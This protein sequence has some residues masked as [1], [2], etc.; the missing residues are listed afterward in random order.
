MLQNEFIAVILAGGQGTRL[1]LLT[2][3]LA[4][5]AVPFGGRYRIIDF[6][7]SNCY[8]SRVDTVG[9][10][11]QYQPFEL[12][13]HVGAGGQEARS[14]GGGI[15]ILPPYMK[16]T[17]GE[18]YK[19]TAN[20]VYQ[21][22]DFIQRYNPQ[23]VLVLSGDHI[24]KM[25]YRT[26]IEQHKQKQAEVTIAAL[27]VPW[28]EASRFG[29]MDI[30]ENLRISQFDEKPAKPRSN[31]ASMGIYVFNWPLLH[32]YLMADE[33]DSSSGHDFGKNVLPAMLRDG[34]AMFA[35]PFDGYWMDVGT[36]ESLWKANMD[37][38]SEN[39][40]LDLSD[41]D[42]PV[43]S[44]DPVQ[45]PHMVSGQASTRQSLISE[46]CQV[47]GRVERSVLFPGVYVAPGAFVK[48]SVVMPN[49]IIG[50][51]TRVIGS[52]IGSGAVIQ[53]EC[54]IGEAGSPEITVIAECVSVPFQTKI[55]ASSGE[56]G[57]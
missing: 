14:G 56:V 53:D 17:G 22:S 25:D 10:L 11:T 27:K 29:V 4:K 24:Y 38:L 9:I 26:I 32:T 40:L 13:S 46:G 20:A 45:P 51:N 6:T 1:S 47:H 16:D 48:D 57:K 23:Y 35:Y 43:Y 41:A 3:N 7:L 2:K 19:G 21:N 33:Q 28:E 34:C 30:D 39:S 8:N 12:H 37:L 54:E 36:V 31:L 15:F 55:N 5:P 49:S 44:V 50:A 52:I 42:W 18:W